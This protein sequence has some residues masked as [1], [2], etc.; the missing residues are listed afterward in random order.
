M[1]KRVTNT[2]AANIRELL[3]S[4]RSIREVAKM[5]GRSPRTIQRIS[6]KDAPAQPKLIPEGG[7]DPDAPPLKRP[8]GDTSA[9]EIF[10]R[11]RRLVP[12]EDLTEDRIKRARAV[13]DVLEA[14]AR[15]SAGLLLRLVK[16]GRYADTAAASELCRQLLS[17]V[18]A[19]LRRIAEDPDW[20][21]E[22]CGIKA[23]SAKKVSEKLL[24]YLRDY[25]AEELRL[26]PGRRDEFMA[27]L[28]AAEDAKGR[29]GAT[30][31]GAKTG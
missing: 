20:V 19:E 17:L 14:E 3:A 4:G 21:A 5:V 18:A 6:K 9:E 11:I 30:V 1:A 16:E 15:S 2:E 25:V 12:P 22:T 27:A 10:D 28:K 26:L 23:A 31:R 13:A 8:P 24:P 29:G 7:E